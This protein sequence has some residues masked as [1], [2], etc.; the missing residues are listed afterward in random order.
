[1][2][3]S[4]DR[5][6]NLNRVWQT[7]DVR[8]R[9]LLKQTGLEWRPSRGG[10][11]FVAHSDDGRSVVCC[12]RDGATVVWHDKDGK[13]FETVA[14]ANYWDPMA[15]SADGR[16]LALCPRE[17]VV[18]LH[19]VASGRKLRELTSEEGALHGFVNPRFSPDGRHLIAGGDVALHLWD[20][21]SGKLLRQGK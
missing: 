12:D 16:L 14:E 7:W 1:V 20:V 15:L 2:S 9:K 18:V 17:N 4:A 21:K 13:R 19:D 3:P 8:T 6:A 10:G 5:R 11:G